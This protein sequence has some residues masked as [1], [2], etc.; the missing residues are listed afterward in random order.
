MTPKLCW[1]QTWGVFP[2][3]RAVPSRPPPLQVGELGVPLG[4]ASEGS[5]APLLLA[6]DMRAPDKPMFPDDRDPF[7]P[8]SD[9]KASLDN[10]SCTL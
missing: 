8:C 6:W 7:K 1:W 10:P 3:Q 9:E 2:R 5:W 4:V